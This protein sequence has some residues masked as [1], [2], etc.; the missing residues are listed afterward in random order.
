MKLQTLPVEVDAEAIAMGLLD[1]F[2]DDERVVL[3]FG[4]LPAGKMECLTKALREKFETIAGE[5]ETPGVFASWVDG[6]R[7]RVEFRMDRLVNEAVHEVCLQLYK[8]GELVV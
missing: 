1:M 6:E 8:H 3:R 7:R 5:T 2:T 4:M